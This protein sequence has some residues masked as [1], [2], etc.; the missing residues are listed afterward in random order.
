MKV[1]NSFVNVL[2]NIPFKQESAKVTIKP[3][4]N[5]KRDVLNIVKQEGDNKTCAKV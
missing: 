3:N 1:Q 5:F 4:K 2:K